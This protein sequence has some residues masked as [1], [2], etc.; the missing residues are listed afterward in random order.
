MLWQLKKLSTNEPLNEAQ[1]LPDNWGPIFGLH[2]VKDRLGDLSWVGPEYIDQ[3]WVEV[4]EETTIPLTEDQA[5]NTISERL[6]Q[7]AWAVAIDNT[8]ITKEDLGI[9]LTYRQAL[10]DIPRQSGYPDIIN[11]PEEPL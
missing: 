9:W 4:G 10:R 2:G 1:R 5:R 6:K 3:G 11:W 8:E 7:S